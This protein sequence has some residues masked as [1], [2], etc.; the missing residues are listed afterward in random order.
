MQAAGRVRP[1]RVRPGPSGRETGA[2]TEGLPEELR[3]RIDA[4]APEAILGRIRPIAF[5]PARI[6]A[7]IVRTAMAVEPRN[8]KL[9]VFMP[10]LATLEDYLDLVAAV[11]E[12]AEDLQT[13]GRSLEGYRLPRD[14]RLNVIKVTPDPGV[15]EVNVAPRQ[16]WHEIGTRSRTGALRRCPPVAPWHR[17]VHARRSP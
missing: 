17:E 15:I 9:N 2:A 5:Q 11:E 4:G 3:K 1:H 10:P 13:A 14:P 16:S 8:G 6:G 12:T 7:L